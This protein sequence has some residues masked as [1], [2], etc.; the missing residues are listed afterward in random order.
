MSN[1]VYLLSRMV[2]DSLNLNSDQRKKILSGIAARITDR[3]CSPSGGRRVTS[4][5]G[6]AFSTVLI[7]LTKAFFL[8]NVIWQL[9]TIGCFIN[10][11]SSVQ[12]LKSLHT[13]WRSVVPSKNSSGMELMTSPNLPRNIMCDIGLRTIG[14]VQRYSLQCVL[15]LNDM[16]EIL[17]YLLYIWLALVF[18]ATALSLLYWGLTCVIPPLTSLV[19]GKYVK[20][21]NQDKVCSEKVGK[22]T[23]AFCTLDTV[24]LLRLVSVSSGELAAQ[25]LTNA[26]WS[27]FQEGEKY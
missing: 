15:P 8:L 22:F 25:E 2:R 6:G 18:I 17:L 26:L 3:R 20:S 27:R 23:F 5:L 7:L 16:T 21:A 11:E 13:V 12:P 4:C 19:I 10:A 14:N 9:R 1:P 24:L